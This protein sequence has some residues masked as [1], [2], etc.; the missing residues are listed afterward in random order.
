MYGKGLNFN[1]SI[2]DDDRLCNWNLWFP[3]PKFLKLN[4][5]IW[6]KVERTLTEEL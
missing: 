1:G 3:P 4:S 5:G 2:A 6:Q